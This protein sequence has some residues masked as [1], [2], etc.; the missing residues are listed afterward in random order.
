MSKIK[1]HFLFIFINF[2]FFI[3]ILIHYIINPVFC[4]LCALQRVTL[5]LSFIFSYLLLLKQKYL[6]NLKYFLLILI[7]I[8]ALIVSFYQI[9]QIFSG[10]Y[11]CEFSIYNEIYYFIIDNIIDVNYIH[12]TGSC[13]EADSI[14]LWGIPYPFYSLFVNI[15]II[16][17][18]IKK[19][20]KS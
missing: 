6:N 2:I 12:A 14:K 16:I 19:M 1:E 7:S 8:S 4:E 18:S 13:S 17:M 9:K 11:S 3:S 20:L 10:V 5:I 15:I